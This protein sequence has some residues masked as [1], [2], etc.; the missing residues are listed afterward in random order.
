MEKNMEEKLLKEIRTI[1]KNVNKKQEILN[2]SPKR[3]IKNKAT[4]IASGKKLNNK[5]ETKNGFR[6]TVRKH[7]V[8]TCLEKTKGGRQR[9]TEY[10]QKLEELINNPIINEDDKKLVKF[11]ADALD[12]S[13]ERSRKARERYLAKK[14]IE[15]KENNEGDEHTIKEV[16]QDEEIIS[17]A[18]D[19]SQNETGRVDAVEANPEE[20]KQESQIENETSGLDSII[21]KKKRK[22]LKP[23]ID[24]LEIPSRGAKTYLQNQLTQTK[25]LEEQPSRKMS[26]RIG[27]KVN[28][29]NPEQDGK[30][31]T[32]AISNK[33]MERIVNDFLDRI[34]FLNSSEIQENAENIR[35]KIENGEIDSSLIYGLMKA[36]ETDSIHIPEMKAHKKEI[37]IAFEQILGQRSEGNLDIIV[38]YADMSKGLHSSNI[39][40]RVDTYKKMDEMK[41]I[42]EIGEFKP[43]IFDRVNKFFK[44]RKKINE[45]EIREDV[46][47]EPTR[48]TEFVGRLKSKQSDYTAE[49]RLRIDERIENRFKGLYR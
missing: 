41:F 10:R 23:S 17:K 39:S 8:S 37:G 35:A 5:I 11:I 4:T 25:S 29:A 7:S 47:A 27:R 19:E 14:A 36:L 31:E 34:K 40:R 43:N 20:A 13:F 22:Q 28:V 15:N 44:K 9:V 2:R 38:D 24:N 18:E 21:T 33:K 26:I 49:K 46:A 16:K 32:F 30:E 3:K 48:H 42:R 1:F 45:I 12:A 6:I